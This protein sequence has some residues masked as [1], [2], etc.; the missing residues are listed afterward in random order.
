M[1]DTTAA[2]VGSEQFYDDGRDTNELSAEA[3]KTE[4]IWNDHIN[5]DGDHEL[6][7]EVEDVAVDIGDPSELGRAVDNAVEFI[8]QETSLL[9]TYDA[10]LVFDG[11]SYPGALGQVSD[12][13][14]A[15]TDEAVGVLDEQYDLYDVVPT[16]EFGHLYGGTHAPS[17]ED[18][19]RYDR[20]G[21]YNYTKS[22]MSLPNDSSMTG[23]F[24]GDNSLAFGTWFAGCTGSEARDCMDGGGNCDL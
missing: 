5:F 10:V 19:W 24:D 15:G 6:S 16:H 11:R 9:D 23:C 3:S 17:P 18:T 4:T 20:D 8:N 2:Y 13:K 7:V 22:V 1:S 14:V 12:I 21:T